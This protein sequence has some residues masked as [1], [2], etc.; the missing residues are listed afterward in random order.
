MTES[1]HPVGY[2]RP[3]RHARFQKGQSGNPGGRPGPKRLAKQAFDAAL[4]KALYADEEVLRQSKPARVIDAFARQVAIN[5]L[6]SQPA[7]QRLLVSILEREDRRGADPDGEDR[8]G[9]EEES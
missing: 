7:A 4:S 5:A 2:G 9:A 8:D 1:P 6:D 3:P